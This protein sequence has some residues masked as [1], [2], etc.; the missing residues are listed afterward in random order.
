[1]PVPGPMGHVKVPSRFG[2]MVRMEKEVLMDGSSM[3]PNF[4]YL[5][6]VGKK[7]WVRIYNPP[8]PKTV[9]EACNRLNNDAADELNYDIKN[10][11]EYLDWQTKRVQDWKL[12]DLKPIDA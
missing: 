2:G 1:M 10:L 3:G 11:R 8:Y 5:D 9:E 6:E 4:Y 12:T 7:S